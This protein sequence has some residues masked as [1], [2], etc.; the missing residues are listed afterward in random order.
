[1][2]IFDLNTLETVEGS[3]VIG[4]TPSTVTGGKNVNLVTAIKQQY[5]VNISLIK[6]AAVNSA[7]NSGVNVS[8]NASTTVFEN[9]AIGPNTYAQSDVSN[10]AIIGQLSESAGT[11][12]AGT[13]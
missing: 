11:L 12:I 4:G 9:T 2:I 1:M 8:G 3:A 5:T 7:L 13:R 6:N 10:T